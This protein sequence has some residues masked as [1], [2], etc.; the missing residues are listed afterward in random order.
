MSRGHRFAYAVARPIH[1]AASRRRAAASRTIWT[2]ARGNASR[3]AIC[4]ARSSTRSLPATSWACT[5][6]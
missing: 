6:L 5:G 4:F 2:W 3:R 1:R